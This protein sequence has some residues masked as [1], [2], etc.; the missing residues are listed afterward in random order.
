MNQQPFGSNQQPTNP[1]APAPSTMPP[2]QP[3]PAPTPA[4]SF[5]SSTSSIPPTSSWTPAQT[6]PTVPPATPTVT[7][8]SSFGSSPIPD[9]TGPSSAPAGS[10]SSPVMMEPAGK[11]SNVVL[12]LVLAVLVIGGAIFAASWFHLI[13]LG[14]ILGIK[15]PTPTPS[16]VITPEPVVNQNDAQRK[17]D[18]ANLKTALQRYYNDKQ[19]YPVATTS[20]KTSDPD[21]ALKVLVPTYVSSLPLDPLSPNNYYSYKSDGKTFQLTSI[22][23]DRT[24]PAGVIIGNYFIYTVTESSAE[25]PNTSTTIFIIGIKNIF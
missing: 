9:L 3:F 12:Y 19:S 13:D 7:S 24:D 2:A 8:T 5:G 16:V 20:T 25:T 18:L 15:K 11:K 1:M 21:T 14:A 4:S 6:P 23:E 17:T 10:S 22:L